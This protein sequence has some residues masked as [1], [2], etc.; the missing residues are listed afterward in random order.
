MDKILDQT[1]VLNIILRRKEDGNIRLKEEKN[2]TIYVKKRNQIIRSSKGLS[3]TYMKDKEFSAEFS[4]L[5]QET[6]HEKWKVSLVHIFSW[7]HKNYFGENELTFQ[8]IVT[9]GGK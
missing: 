7:D 5:Q 1:D 4:L 6:I 9:E 8:D 3:M 2:V